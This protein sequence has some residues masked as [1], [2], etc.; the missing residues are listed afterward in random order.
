[1]SSRPSDAV[2]L[3]VRVDAPIF[4]SDEVVAEAAMPAAEEHEDDEPEEEIVD[5]F[6]EFIDQ[7]NPDDFAS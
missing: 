3:A 5:Q 2:A 4:A 1:V 6:R 7:V